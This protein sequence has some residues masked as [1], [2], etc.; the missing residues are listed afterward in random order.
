MFKKPTPTHLEPYAPLVLASRR[1]IGPDRV[2]VC[3]AFRLKPNNEYDSGWVFWGGDESQEFIDEDENTAVCP[4]LPFLEMDDSL[5]TIVQLP[6]GTAWER[7][8]RES[9]WV[10]VTGYITPDGRLF[11]E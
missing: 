11:D 10:E 8:S 9:A 1:V 3:F 6:V 2:P 7:S 4:M 5:R